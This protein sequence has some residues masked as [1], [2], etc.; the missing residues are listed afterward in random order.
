LR[1]ALSGGHLNT[2]ILRN[3]DN[4]TQDI[5]VVCSYAEILGDAAY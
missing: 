5:G 3:Q 2:K 4:A 1:L